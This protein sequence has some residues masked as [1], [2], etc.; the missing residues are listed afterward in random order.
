MTCTLGDQRSDPTPGR[1]T[2]VCIFCSPRGISV[3]DRAAMNEEERDPITGQMRLT[4]E[5]SERSSGERT[6]GIYISCSVSTRSAKKNK[7]AARWMQTKIHGVMAL[8][9]CPE[10]PDG[11]REHHGFDDALGE[12]LSQKYGFTIV[13]KTYADARPPRPRV[14]QKKFKSAQAQRTRDTEKDEIHKDMAEIVTNYQHAYQQSEMEKAG[15]KGQIETLDR[16][17]VT[18]TERQKGP[19]EKLQAGRKKGAA[20][21]EKTAE[22]AKAKEREKARRS[23]HTSRKTHGTSTTATAPAGDIQDMA[24]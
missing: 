24:L 5:R 18:D 16:A 4:P 2:R 21:A 23:K 11:E 3:K 9:S 13:K 7:D 15:V 6:T 8:R 17:P 14:D 19:C 20:I 22:M 10:D 12:I 1:Q